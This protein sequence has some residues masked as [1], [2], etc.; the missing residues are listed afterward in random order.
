[1]PLQEVITQYARL[2]KLSEVYFYINGGKSQCLKKASDMVQELPKFNLV[3]ALHVSL[4]QNFFGAFFPI[5][6]PNAE[7]VTVKTGNPMITISVKKEARK[8]TKLQKFNSISVQRHLRCLD[9]T[10]RHAKDYDDFV[11]VRNLN[12]SYNPLEQKNPL[13]GMQ[14]DD[15]VIS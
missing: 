5:L 9:F 11:Y 13:A 1:M 12:W 4:D 2:P 10:G 15:C 7:I 8:F 14:P 6:F 3:K